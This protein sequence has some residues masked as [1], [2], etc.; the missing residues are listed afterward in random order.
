M[1]AAIVHVRSLAAMPTR[2]L[3][4]VFAVP[5]PV[6]PMHRG[7]QTVPSGNSTDER[8]GKG[9]GPDPPRWKN[10]EEVD[11]KEWEIRVG[12]SL[13]LSCYLAVLTLT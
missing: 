7:G 3:E 1:V 9:K 4:P 8:K 5:P 10:E 13:T 6:N 2:T 11:D 12:E